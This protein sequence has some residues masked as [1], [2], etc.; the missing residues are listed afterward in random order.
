VD[1]GVGRAYEKLH[2]PTTI[3]IE[4]SGVGTAL[5]A[6]LQNCGLPVI[7]AKVEH[8]KET[9][10]SIQSGKFASGQ[11]FF[12]QQAP[13][14]DELEAELFAF[15][16]S[17]HDDQ[18]DSISQALSFEIRRPLWDDKSIEGLNRLVT[19][20][21]MDQYFGWLAGRPW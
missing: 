8:N 17:R 6:E 7:A 2:K 12:P 19:G 1:A 16:G 4:D 18:V 3:L 20:L 13:W 5:L 14:L 11:V 10:M 15:P 9:R 21:A